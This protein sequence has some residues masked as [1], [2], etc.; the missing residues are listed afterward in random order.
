[1]DLFHALLSG[2][3]HTASLVCS[4]TGDF[5]DENGTSRGL[6]GEL[7]KVWLGAL[8]SRVDVVLTSGKTFR[9]EQYRMPK[10]ADLAVLSRHPVDRSTLSIAAGQQLIEFGEADYEL[11]ALELVQRGHKRIHLEFGP[12]GIS[13]LLKSSFEFD[14]WL[15]GLSE[16]SVALGAQSLGLEA[17]I[18]ANLDGLSLALAR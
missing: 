9:A 11:S 5:V 15:S 14:L 17:H 13:S 10:Q 6:G 2:S 4:S 7:D 8:R 12:S 1:M 18:I 3:N 16:S